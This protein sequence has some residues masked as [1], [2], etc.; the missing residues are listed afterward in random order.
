[1]SA[2]HLKNKKLFCIGHGL[3]ADIIASQ[4]IKDGGTVVSTTRTAEKAFSLNARGI[5][6]HLYQL[7]SALPSKMC[8]DLEQADLIL[9]STPPADFPCD[10]TPKLLNQ[11]KLN[12][13]AW[14]FYLS[15]TGVYGDHQ[16]RIVTEDTPPQPTQKRSIKRLASELAWQNLNQNNTSMSYHKPI[17]CFRLAGIY[18]AKRNALVS[19][20]KNLDE[21]LPIKRILKPGI[22]FGRIHAND[23]ANTIF[24]AWR[25]I[26]LQH[27][28]S[29]KTK[30][31]KCLIYNVC[32]DL[33]AAQCDVIA[34]ACM[35]LNIPIP[36]PLAYHD[37]ELTQAV[38]SF[39]QDNRLIC[40]KRIKNELGVKLQFSDYRSGLSFEA[41]KI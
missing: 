1:M 6:T 34:Y 18:G 5:E 11:A 25:A 17:C 36:A 10:P 8:F 23:I 12:I 28:S 37:G 24:C 29:D 21:N 35:L 7:G 33:P 13:T 30:Y 27:L 26:P 2:N 38:G 31:K 32:D 39:Y 16:G 40:N 41:S 9:V 20:K 4:W 15:A 14:I 3:S 22:R 19:I